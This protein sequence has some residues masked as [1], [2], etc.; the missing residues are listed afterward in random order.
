MKLYEITGELVNLIQKYNES[1]NQEQLDALEAAIKDVQLSFDEKVVA[2]THHIINIESDIPAIKAEKE[3]LDKLEESITKQA[4]WFRRYVKNSMEAIGQ[5]KV[6]TPTLKISIVNNPPSV[7]VD[8]EN[9]IPNQYKRAM[10]KCE[11]AGMAFDIKKQVPDVVVSIEVNKTKIKEANKLDVGVS[12]A[13][14]E[15]KKRLSIK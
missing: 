12:G 4:E 8:D 9:I 15:T 10:I 1:E 7:V 2:V 6:T 5:D 3:R 11:D 13:H 14:I